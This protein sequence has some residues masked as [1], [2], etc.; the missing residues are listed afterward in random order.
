MHLLNFRAE[1]LVD[2]IKDLKVK[3]RFQFIIETDKWI[4]TTLGRKE[5]NMYSRGAKK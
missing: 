5:E 3:I 2:I 1:N 4:T